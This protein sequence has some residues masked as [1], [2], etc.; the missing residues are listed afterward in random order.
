MITDI[1]RE[2]RPKDNAT[3]RMVA[4]LV[5]A[6]ATRCCWPRLGVWPD[7]QQMPLRAKW[8]ARLLGGFGLGAGLLFAASTQRTRRVRVQVDP[9][10][11]SLFEEDRQQDC[12]WDDVAVVKETRRPRCPHEADNFG[13]MM[14]WVKGENHM[15]TLVARVGNELVLKNV[16]QDFPALVDLVKQET[17]PRLL[18]AAQA[19]FSAGEKLAFG[20]ISVDQR[21]VR[22]GDA[23]LPWEEV[24]A[25]TAEKGVIQI[26]KR[27]KWLV[28]AQEPVTDVPNAHILIAVAQAHLGAHRQQA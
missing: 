7:F 19:S 12:R 25:F 18:P 10:G 1:S 27:E 3:V 17:L 26:R 16:V 8:Q 28:W 11:V 5:V 22:L 14:A 2:F 6:A 4:G 13:L 21:E 20:R 24:D 15:L 9:G 23:S